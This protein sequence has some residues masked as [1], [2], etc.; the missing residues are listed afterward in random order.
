MDIFLN[1]NNMDMISP[2]FIYRAFTAGQMCRF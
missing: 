1:P 2:W